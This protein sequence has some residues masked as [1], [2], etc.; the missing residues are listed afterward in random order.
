M[1]GKIAKIAAVAAL[2]AGIVFAQAPAARGR[3]AQRALA[4]TGGAMQM[5]V[6]GAL[7][8]SDAQKAAIQ[9]INQQARQSAQ[10]LQP[11]FKVNR[12]AMAD[13]V[14]LNDTAKITQIATALGVLQGQL[15]A[16][17]SGARAKVYAILTPEQKTKLEQIQKRL[18]NARKAA[19]DALQ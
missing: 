9:T 2:A 4:R 7:N 18:Q 13:A 8:L 11:Q 1:T 12:Q 10:L 17:Q 16:I 14:K 5:R 19:A 3:L 15:I 6:L